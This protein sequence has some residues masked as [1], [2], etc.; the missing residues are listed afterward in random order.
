M[1]K[2]QLV[3]TGEPSCGKSCLSEPI[4]ELLSTYP[5]PQDGASACKWE[6]ICLDD[7]CHSHIIDCINAMELQKSI[8]DSAVN[9][10]EMLCLYENSAKF[11]NRYLKRLPANLQI[12]SNTQGMFYH[13]NGRRVDFCSIHERL[14]EI[15]LQNGRLP[16][17]PPTDL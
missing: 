6:D 1:E 8:K 13:K 3:F 5:I 17:V 9:E 7:F 11:D 12:L 14:E 16:K 2:Q 4:L 10:A 15:C